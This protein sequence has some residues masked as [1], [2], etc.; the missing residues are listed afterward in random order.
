MKN[1]KTHNPLWGAT[2]MMLAGAGFACVNTVL[3]YLGMKLGLAST[4]ATFL[5]YTIALL[6]MLPFLR[7]E[8]LRTAFRSENKISHISRIVVSVIGVQLWTYALAHV[9]IWQGIALLMTSPLFATIGSALFLR[10]GISP[11]RWAATFIGFIGAMMILAPWSDKFSYYALLPIGAAFFWSLASLLTK[12]SSNNN[13]SPETIVAYLLVLMFPIHL[14]F[15]IAADL[16]TGFV[17]PTGGVMLWVLVIGAGALTAFA[18]WAIAK[19]YSVADA[20]YVQPFDNA[21][22]PLNVLAGFIVFGY[23]PPGQLWLGSAIIIASVT[24]I[25]HYEQKAHRKLKKQPV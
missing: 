3:Q 8:G 16:A 20:S 2:W 6:V 5:Q 11:A 24:F 19:A 10:E 13:D 4:L 17:F 15:F 12:H 21:K 25:T 23:V 22:L 7:T 14:F 9:P 18:Q 1:T